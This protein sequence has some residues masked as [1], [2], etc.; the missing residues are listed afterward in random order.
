LAI[1]ACGFGIWGLY[2]DAGRKE[3]PEL[4]Y[5]IPDLSMKLGMILFGMDALFL[6]M[7]LIIRRRGIRNL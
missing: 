7:A 2:T 5:I 4:A 1:A 6:S 3:Y